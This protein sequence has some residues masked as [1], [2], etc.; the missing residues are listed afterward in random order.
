MCLTF[1]GR[2]TLPLTDMTQGVTNQISATPWGKLQ[3]G[4]FAELPQVTLGPSD[5]SG[6][7]F[8]WRS[9]DDSGNTAGSPSQLC[10]RK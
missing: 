8:S 10:I 6:G 1:A 3:G 4:G 9:Q 7:S 5:Q 2:A